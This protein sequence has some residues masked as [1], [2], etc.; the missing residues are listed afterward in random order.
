[1]SGRSHNHMLPFFAS[2]DFVGFRPLP[3]KSPYHLSLDLESILFLAYPLWAPCKSIIRLSGCVGTFQPSSV[4]KVA[5]WKSHISGVS[6]GDRV[7]HSVAEVF[8]VIA[9]YWCL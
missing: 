3:A 1:M 2:M 4:R 6:F 9:T 7:S 8:I 5:L